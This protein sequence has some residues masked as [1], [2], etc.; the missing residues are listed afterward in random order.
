MFALAFLMVML[1]TTTVVAAVLRLYVQGEGGIFLGGETWSEWLLQHSTL[2]ALVAAGTLALM[3]LAS[4]YRAATLARGG[5]QVARMVGG[6]QVT[7]EGSDLLHR[8]LV[9]VVE[10]MALASGVPVPEIFI[11][12]EEP[13]INAFAA[14]L[15]PTDAAIA[16][17][18][19]ALERLD[20]A[21]LQG[22]I[23]HE[24][25]HVLN[26]DMRLNQQLI[27]LSFGILVL[28]LAGRWLLR[29]ARFARRGR[30]SG[31]A[32]AVALGLS[33]TVIGAIGMLFSRMIKAAVSR[34]RERLA[35][36]SAV[37]F[38]REPS[39]LAGAL[40]KIGG[41]TARLS[42]V[43]GEE[44]AHMLFERGSR[45]FGGLF[46]TH[47]PL[48]ERIQALD[49]S[50]RPEDFARADSPMP[51]SQSGGE[52][53][54]S[55][56]PSAAEAI[57]GARAVAT[58]DLLQRVGLIES[59]E[60]GSTLRA[61][62]PEEVYHAAHARESSL[63]LVLALALAETEPTRR[64]QLALIEGQLGPE[65]ANR[66][67]KLH[68]ELAQLDQALRMPVLELSL[69]ALKLRPSEQ[70]DYLFELLERLA[71]LDSAQRLFDYVLTR[72]LAAYL[73]RRSRTAPRGESAAKLSSREAV[74]VLLTNVAAF[75]HEDA[76]SAHAAY[77]AGLAALG[78][79]PAGSAESAF[80]T[81]ATARDL[82]KLD[83]ALARLATLAPRAQQRVLAGVLATIRHDRKIE[84]AEVELF[85]AIS[86][87]L[88][89][90]LP[91]SAVPHSSEPLASAKSGA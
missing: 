59:A 77:R 10:E 69:P 28:S 70:L 41:Y 45:A 81:L 35:D 58:D 32:A 30:N 7:G 39:S 23:A 17:T 13:A 65:R 46:A 63:W 25:S 57:S 6:T 43:D 91:P 21:E 68:G 78:A 5:G 86:A 29:S 14:G 83:A 89:C 2:L 27:G 85:R 44:I 9:N 61:A 8:R 47:P 82:G 51:Q 4:L 71:S 90:P 76:A 16:V 22:V 53:V 74:R 75:G 62:L 60:V 73:P 54:H 56:A 31:M 87:S 12:E 18:R 67:R 88:G 33:L 49:P 66:V 72:L 34:Q 37:Q 36:A 64:R 19:G 48:V 3:A 84:V 24:F 50:F 52:A 40:K 80:G 26:G 55:L 15:T 79:R 20:R 38:T 1:A 42:S 11:L